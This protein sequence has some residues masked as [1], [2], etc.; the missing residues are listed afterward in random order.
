[1]GSNRFKATEDVGDGAWV[2]DFYLVQCC[3]RLVRGQRG[4]LEQ[5]PSPGAG[6]GGPAECPEVTPLSYKA[7]ESPF[8]KSG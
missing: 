6:P 7:P 5:G 3:P 8:L 4:G 2:S 1:M